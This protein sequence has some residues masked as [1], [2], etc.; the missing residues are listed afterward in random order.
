MGRATMLTIIPRAIA[1]GLSS[2]ERINDYNN[3]PQLIKKFL[4]LLRNT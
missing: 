1:E 2:R 3:L 4:M